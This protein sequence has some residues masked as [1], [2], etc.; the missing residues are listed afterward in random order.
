L[1]GVESFKIVQETMACTRVFLV[2]AAGFDPASIARIE[3]GF[4]RRLGRGVEV[5]VELVDAVPLEA[6]GKFRYVVSR[7]SP[8]VPEEAT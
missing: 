2:P 3:Q 6:S 4:K 1:P 8:A 5:A 7:V